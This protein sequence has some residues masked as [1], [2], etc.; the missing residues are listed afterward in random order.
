MPSKSTTT[1]QMEVMEVRRGELMFCVKGTSPLI[2]NRLSEKTKREL[3]LPK[4]RKT[5]SEKA[6]S[7][8]HNPLQE[9]R[10]AA[11]WLASPA[12]TLLGIPSTAFKGAMMTAALDMEGLTKAGIGR[13]VYVTSDYIGVYGVPKLHMTPVRSADMNKTPDIR[14]RV[15][16]PEWAAT[17]VVQFVQPIMRDKIVAN[18]MAAAGIISG[19]GDFRPEKGKGAY[20]QFELVGQDDKDFKRIIKT[21]ARDVQVQAMDDAEP[22]DDESRELLSWFTSEASDR[23]WEFDGDGSAR[24]AD[25]GKAVAVK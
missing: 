7:L 8:K 15:I 5:A 20:G 3:L 21:G 2:L 16:V 4:G 25:S 6:S 24:R 19:V 12:E 23:G 17:V 18:L 22:Y 11:H 1:K 10:S 13:H 14:T 9:F